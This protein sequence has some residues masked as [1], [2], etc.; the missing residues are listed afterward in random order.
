MVMNCTPWSNVECVDQESGTLAH[1][2]APVPGELATMSWRLP[3]TPS[4]SSGTS[5]LVIYTLMG[6]GI[7]FVL[8]G[9]VVCCFSKG[10]VLEGKEEVLA[11]SS[12]SLVLLFP[13][14][15]L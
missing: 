10:E 11:P 5:P 9:C 13:L 7:T 15:C 8:M 14:A 12:I 3:S 2:E 6:L 1:G 4:P